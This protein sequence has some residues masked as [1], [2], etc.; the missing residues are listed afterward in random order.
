M[1]RTSLFAFLIVVGATATASAVPQTM[2]FTA[3]ITDTSGNPIDGNVD[4]VFRVFDAVAGGT[5]IWEETQN[6]LVADNGLLYA[7]LGSI[8]PTNNGLDEGVF[9]G[10]NRWLEIVV[11]GDTLSPRLPLISVPYAVKA[12]SSDRLGSLAESDV[13][14]RVTGTCPAG[15]SIRAVAADGSVTC[16]PDDNS[17]GDVT[18]VTAGAGLTGGGAS[19]DVTLTVDTSAIQERV[20][21]TCAAGSSI[22][23]IAADGTVTCETDDDTNSGG[24]IT[25]VTA[26]AG[27]NGGGATGAVTLS[28]DTT[29]IQSRVGGT[30]PAGS[31]IR[32]VAVDGTVTCETDDDTN[33]GGDITGVT[34]GFG[35]TGGGASGAVTLSVD[36]TAVQARV[37]GTCAAG[38]S[39]RVVA[40]DG[41]VTCEADTDSGGD[42]TGVTAGTGL[43]GGGASGAVSLSVDSTQVQ[44]RVTGTCA[45]GSSIRVINQD[46]SVTCEPDDDTGGTGDITGV[47]AGTGLSGG[48]TSGNVTLSVDPLQVQDRVTGTCAVGSAIRIINQNG[49][50]GCEIDDDSGGDITSVI[51]GTGLTGGGTAGDVTLGIATGGVTSTH[52]ADGGIAAVDI[53]ANQVTMAKTSAP[54]GVGHGTLT[55]G[56]QYVAQLIYPTTAFTA[57]ADGS[58]FATAKLHVAASASAPGYVALR[59]GA[60]QGAANLVTDVMA[61]NGHPDGSF[62]IASFSYAMDVGVTTGQHLRQL[63]ASTVFNVIAGNVYRFGCVVEHNNTNTLGGLVASCQVQYVC[64]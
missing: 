32:A 51:G 63:D 58:C 2:S 44:D 20:T 38:S 55:L 13:Q 37:T 26:G 19:G 36:T 29:A 5:M 22:R 9:D 42:I 54:I 46:G 45:A 41:T 31:S 52:L 21:G 3:R 61:L 43:S 12:G 48:G 30:C 7:A 39:I 8:D 53:G 11:A 18:G 56:P 64:Q 60:Q 50:V 25:G 59:V 1:K 28:V 17:G 47:T 24:D 6:G 4:V 16:E 62:P 23:T 15:Q 34:A 35:L 14:E 49:T 27:L 33:S 10:S 40:A 57:D